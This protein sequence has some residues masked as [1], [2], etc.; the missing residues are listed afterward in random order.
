MHK[1]GWS[2]LFVQVEPTFD[3]CVFAFAGVGI[4]G[5]AAHLA[6]NGSPVIAKLEGMPST[7][8]RK[9]VSVDPEASS[10]HKYSN[11]SKTNGE[12]SLC[13]GF[14]L[15]SF[16]CVYFDRNYQADTF[17][18]YYTLRVSRSGPNSRGFSR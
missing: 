3:G 9:P 4:I 5:P 13:I 10:L 15:F 6:V 16:G 17:P 8:I 7:S 14:S 12:M 1:A 2:V 18:V 11:S